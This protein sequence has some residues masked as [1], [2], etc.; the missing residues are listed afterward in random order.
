MV[1]KSADGKSGTQETDG[2]ANKALGTGMSE[3]QF[4][5]YLEGDSPISKAFNAMEQLEPPPTLDRAILHEAREAAVPARKSWLDLDLA[6]WRHWAKP[7]TT[8]VIMGVCLTV[9][10]RV[11]DYASLAPPVPEDGPFIAVEQKSATLMRDKRD[12]AAEQRAAEAMA[13]GANANVRRM[14]TPAATRPAGPQIEDSVDSVNRSF[15]E[16]IRVTAREQADAL[17]E[18]V[19]SA[20]KREETLQEVPLAISALTDADMAEYNL[21]SMQDDTIV[22]LADDALAA[23][24]QGARPAADVWL[25]GI[26]ALYLAKEAEPSVAE[27]DNSAIGMAS[28]DATAASIELAK[29]ALVY[30]AEARQF[31]ER[32]KLH[33]RFSAGAGGSA[34]DLDALA[35]ESAASVGTSPVDQLADPRVWNAGIDWLYKNDR[36]EEAAAELARLS[37]VYPDF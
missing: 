4:E 20:R 36:G 18:I 11:M 28:R 33:S 13:D 7:L 8:A 22:V 29:M 37:Q 34:K 19:V 12:F 32:E 9:V 31:S 30:P 35:P 26:E 17:Q 5:Q 2:A 27:A 25:A 16:E 6:F 10:L 14:R 21:Y 3:E 24:E 1:K 15:Q 23:W